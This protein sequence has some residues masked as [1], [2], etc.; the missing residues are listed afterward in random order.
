MVKLKI[1]T[2]QAMPLQQV[3][4]E[5][6]EVMVATVERELQVLVARELPVQRAAQVALH[7]AEE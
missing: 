6:S 7:L 4:L 3:V 2:R 1:H 5:V